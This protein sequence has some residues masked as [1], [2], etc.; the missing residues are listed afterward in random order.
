MDHATWTRIN[1]S[2]V[3]ARCSLKVTK[4]VEAHPAPP[5][6]NGE[7][8]APLQVVRL[9]AILT[10][11]VGDDT[12]RSFGV[13]LSL[14]PLEVAKLDDWRTWWLERALAEFRN[15]GELAQAFATNAELTEEEWL[16]SEDKPL[17]AE[18]S[19]EAPFSAKVVAS[20]DNQEEAEACQS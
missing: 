11:L 17:E 4:R 16:E 15:V 10:F 19:L 1:P 8:P 7:A 9:E 18:L 14:D 20:E 12:P 5:G 13:G 3:T 2:Q 6:E